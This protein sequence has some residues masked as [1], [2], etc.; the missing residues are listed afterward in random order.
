MTFDLSTAA[1]PTIAK[2]PDATLDYSTDWTAWLAQ[3][4][5]TISSFQV[6]Y[7]GVTQSVAPSLAGNVITAWVSGGT[8]GAMASITFRVL[9]VAGRTEERTIYLH[10][11]D[12]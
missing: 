2:D 9:T 6:F 8:R 3:V 12:R 5:D 10:I 1:R 11:M 7:S 4:A